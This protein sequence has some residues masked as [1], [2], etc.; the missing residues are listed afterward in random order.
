MRRPA[1]RR[2]SIALRAAGPAIAPPTLLARVQTAWPEAAGGALAAAATPVA[3]REGV[4]TVT[5][6][7]AVWAQELELLASDLLGRLNEALG[8]HDG[9]RISR[10]RFVVGSPSNFRSSGSP[11]HRP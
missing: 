8:P 2:L 7:S 5:C 9:E 11:P 10:L 4:V 6:E 3:E 1:P